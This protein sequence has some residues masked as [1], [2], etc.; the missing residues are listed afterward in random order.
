M[1]EFIFK[2]EAKTL[3]KK[4][5]KSKPLAST[6]NYILLTKDGTL[7]VEKS[8]YT[9]DMMGVSED[10]NYINTEENNKKE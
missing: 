3:P 9:E 5:A 4:L 2:E 10:R 7:K 8:E 6:D 1:T